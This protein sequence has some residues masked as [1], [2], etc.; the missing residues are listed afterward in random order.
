M[1][2]DID[3]FQRLINQIHARYLQTSIQIKMEMK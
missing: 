1:D 2:I 3:K